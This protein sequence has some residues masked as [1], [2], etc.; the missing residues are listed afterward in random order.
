[1][2]EPVGPVTKMMPCGRWMSG[3]SSARWSATRPSCSRLKSI[4]DDSS[5]ISTVSPKLVGSTE[6]RRSRSS[7]SSPT[8]MRP[9][10]GSLRSAM[11]SCAITLIRET[12]AW[13]SRTRSAGVETSY[14]TPSMRWRTRS[15]WPKGSMWMSVARSRTA[16]RMSWLTNEMTEASS[17][18]AVRSSV[19]LAT[20]A[21]SCSPVSRSRSTAEAPTP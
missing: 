3:T 6:M 12:T 5:R 7:P 2:P 8:L 21:A 15:V 9:S 19:R 1:M 18:L 13:W 16:E 4:W 10:C 11:S 20:G 14:M 17:G